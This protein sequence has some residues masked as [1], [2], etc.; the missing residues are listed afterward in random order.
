MSVLQLPHAG[1][2]DF[3]QVVFSDSSPV[4]VEFFAP[5]CGHCQRMAPIMEE[6]ARDYAGRLRIVQFNVDRNL[7]TPKRLGIRGVPTMLFFVG[8]EEIDRIVGEIP[9]ETLQAHIDQALPSAG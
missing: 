9:K 3:D 2:S 6:T 4:L 7:E 5:W 1:D 8:G